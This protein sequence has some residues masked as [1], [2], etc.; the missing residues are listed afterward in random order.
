MFVNVY[1]NIGCFLRAVITVGNFV[2]L[3]TGFSIFQ[4]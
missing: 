3:E 2:V 4:H 1:L